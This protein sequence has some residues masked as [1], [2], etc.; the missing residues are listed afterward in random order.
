[1]R[2]IFDSLINAE[3]SSRLKWEATSRD[4]TSKDGKRERSK[5][6]GELVFIS[7]L[8]ILIKDPAFFLFFPHPSRHILL[9][10]K[11]IQLSKISTKK[12]RRNR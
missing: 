6:N 2:L 7:K 8:Q 9:N 10:G 1:M 4:P 11:F 3:I 5:G 12:F